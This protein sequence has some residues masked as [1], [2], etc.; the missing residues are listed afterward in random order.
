MTKQETCVQIDV[1]NQRTILENFLYRQQE[2]T[3]PSMLF[4]IKQPTNFRK[5]I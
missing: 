4:L 2:R 3:P 5:I 1:E